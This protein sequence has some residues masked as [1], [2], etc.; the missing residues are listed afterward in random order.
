MISLLCLPFL[1][2]PILRKEFKKRDLRML[3]IVM[4]VKS[5][6]NSI[7][8]NFKSIDEANKENFLF[9][10]YIFI[11]NRQEISEIEKDI[12]RLKNQRF[13]S[14]RK[15]YM[16][17]KLPQNS[18]VGDFV[19]ILNLLKITH[20]YRYVF[21]MRYD[22]FYIYRTLPNHTPLPPI[23]V[24]GGIVFESDTNN[25]LDFWADKLNIKY[26]IEIKGRDWVILGAFVFFCFF[27]VARSRRP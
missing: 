3:T 18:T 16:A 21:D 9:S 15:I 23:S 7:G 17:I 12:N 22:V 10:T 1:L 4:P 27:S 5:Y 11:N 24:C 13:M 25:T 14:F 20:Q 6:E 19:S 26:L 2:V 8:F